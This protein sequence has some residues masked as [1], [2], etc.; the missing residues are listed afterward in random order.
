MGYKNTYAMRNFVILSGVI[1]VLSCNTKAVKFDA[2][3]PSYTGVD[4]NNYLEESDELNVLNYTYF[5]NGGGVAVGDLNNDGLPDLVFT[6]NM[7]R[8]KLFINKGN[9]K[10]EDIT[11]SSGIADKQGWCTGVSMVDI[12][13]DGWLDIYICR[14]AD[15]DPEKR[16]NLLFVNNKNN[17]FSEQA[18]DHGLA[19]P[20]YSTQSAFF[21]YD[22]DGDLDCVVINHSLKKYTTGVS[23]NPQLRQEENPFFGSRLYRNDNG[24]FTDVS[25]STGIVSNVLSFGLGVLVNDFNSDGW[26]DFFISN[27]FNEPDYLFINQQ[28]G[29]FKE[30]GSSRLS[31]HSLYSMGAD[32]SDI[33]HDGD[34]DLVTLDMLPESNYDQKKHSGAENF[35]KF[36]YLFYKGFHNQYSRNMLHLNNGDG[37]FSEI[38]QLAGISNTDWSWAALLKDFDNDGETDLFV[39]NGYVRDYTDMDFI[40]YSFDRQVELQQSGGSDQSLVAYIKKMPGHPL[41]NYMF[42]SK[43]GLQFQNVSKAWGFNKVAVFSGASAG[44]LDLDGDLDLVLTVTNGKAVIYKNNAVLQG[45]NFL[46]FSFKGEG[47]NLM[48]LGTVVEVYAKGVMQKQEHHLSRGFQSSME[49]IMHFGLASSPKADSVKVIWP[50]GRCQVLKNIQSGQLVALRQSE[51][52]S[53]STPAAFNKP[54]YVS[55][56]KRSF[57]IKDRY[58]SDFSIQ[59]SINNFLTNVSPVLAVADFN[60]DGEDDLVVGATRSEPTR[61]LIKSKVQYSFADG[62]LSPVSCIVP[63]D[64]NGDGSVDLVIGR[65]A[66]GAEPRPGLSLQCFLNTGGNTFVP[67]R[68]TMPEFNMNVGSI[69]IDKGLKDGYTKIF[70]GSRVRSNQYPLSDTSR[71]FVFSAQGEFLYQEALPNK[72]DLGMITGAIFCDLDG[73][74]EKE[75]LIVGEFKPISVFRAD[76]S[77][78]VD[79]SRDYFPKPMPGWWNS[80]HASDLDG[81]G[82]QD[83]IAGNYGLNTQFK[84]SDSTP[85][86]IL[87]KDFDGNGKLDAVTS[88]YIKGNAHPSHSL[89]DLLEQMP[90]LRKKFNTYASYANVSTDQLF[91]PI[92]KKDARQMS[93][94]EMRTLVFENKKGTGLVVHDLPIQAQFAPVFASA[95]LDID[96]DGRKD[97]LLCGNQSGTRI[98]YGKYDA[99]KGFVFVNKGGF[100]F[101]FMEPAK[102]G[103]RIEGDVR[104]ISI[105]NDGRELFFGLNGAAIKVYRKTP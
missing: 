26:P 13:N 16:K 37:G 87:Y 44:D 40:K 104:S 38:G 12:N 66:Y 98:K 96:G 43:G 64:L 29:T 73:K 62:D 31:Q 81:D 25:K 11:S 47:Q 39:T 103:I 8:N 48:G 71:L 93:A 19:D 55:D 77:I 45:Q 57:V 5:Y 22:K 17:T 6:G 20:G 84:V 53:L 82:D 92:Q 102:T 56:D 1:L 100:N 61:I 78:W 14:S 89:D 91:T 97:L 65:N 88:Y 49:P 15:V 72:G 86:S 21:D 70:V 24:F 67:M 28:N 23:D 30:E 7:V 46:R 35:D 42:R 33:D 68:S 41:S 59:P 94:S 3:S 18:Q 51:A 2:L 75:L 83:I 54:Y 10:F 60:A 32:A 90:I 80:I 63:T 79:C 85:V 105:L 52:M 69:A 34:A 99:N 9:M 36:R 101:S 4:F 74:G 58:Q 27:D 76:K 50:D 95:I